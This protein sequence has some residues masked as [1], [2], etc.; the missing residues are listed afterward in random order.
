MHHERSNIPGAN[1]QRRIPRQHGAHA[2]AGLR[3]SR[4]DRAG[5][6]GRFRSRT[7]KVQGARQALRRERIDLL[8]DPGAPFLELSPLAANGMYGGDVPGAGIVTGIGRVSGAGMRDRGQRCDRQ[9]RHLFSA[10]REEA[11]ARA[12]DRAARTGCHASTWWTRAAPFCPCRTRYSRTGSTSGAIFY[13]QA[14]LSAA[15]IP[16]I[17]CVMGSCTA[18]GAY[19]PGDVR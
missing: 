14:N 7:Q 18:G 17:A 16:Q 15:G 4:E 2:G 10:H 5:S 1:A 19:M 6:T 8:L 9:G 11:P 13:N 3:T 12:G